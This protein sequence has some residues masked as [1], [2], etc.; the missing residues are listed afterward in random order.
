[1]KKML[2]TSGVIA[3]ASLL[4]GCM[5]ISCDERGAMRRPYVIGGPSCRV[6]GVVFVPRGA[7]PYSNDSHP[8]AWR[9]PAPPLASCLAEKP[10]YNDPRPDNRNE[11]PDRTRTRGVARL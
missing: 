2:L 6:A 7:G 1:M 8:R 4:S 11:S 10:G 9:R 3:A 5:V